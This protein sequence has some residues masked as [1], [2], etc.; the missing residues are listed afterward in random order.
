MAE[1]GADDG[2]G[3]CAHEDPG[4]EHRRHGSGRSVG[5]FV[6]DQFARGKKGEDADRNDIAHPMR[7]GEIETDPAEQGT[8]ATTAGAVNERNPAT[9]P[10]NRAN[11]KAGRIDV[12][13]SRRSSQEGELSGR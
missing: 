10:I 12:Y 13:V 11:V 1:W 5:E 2:A 4:A 3:K 9:T 6:H 7:P 8:Q